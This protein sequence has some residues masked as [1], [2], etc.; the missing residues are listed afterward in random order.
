MRLE[1]VFASISVAGWLFWNVYIDAGSLHARS[2]L[3]FFDVCERH[4]DGCLTCRFIRFHTYGTI[5]H[6]LVLRPLISKNA[7]YDDGKQQDSE[8]DDADTARFHRGNLVH[9]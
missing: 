3:I 5:D 8:S 2:V 9:S 1:I 4:I 7:A 6:D